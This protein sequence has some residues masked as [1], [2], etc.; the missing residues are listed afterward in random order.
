MVTSITSGGALIGTVVAGL[1]ADR[2]GRK[3]VIYVGCALFVLGAILQATA[4]GVIQ[5]TSGRLVVGFGIGS[6][7]MV[8]PVRTI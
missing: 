2:Y 7:A 5:M 4:F 3:G 6:V 8:I 1:T